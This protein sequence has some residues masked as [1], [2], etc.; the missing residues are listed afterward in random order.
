MYTKQEF[1]KTIRDKYPIYDDMDDD[2]LFDAVIKKYPE[3]STQIKKEDTSFLKETWKWIADLAKAWGGWVMQA[4]KDIINIA[5]DTS[6]P[7]EWGFIQ[8]TANTIEKK[9]EQ[10]REALD[11]TGW[12]KWVY[13]AGGAVVWAGVDVFGDMIMSWIKTIAPD[14]MEK[15]VKEVVQDKMNNTN[16]GQKIISLMN[17]Y[18]SNMEFLKKNDPEA[19][20]TYSA[21]FSYLSWLAEL[22][23]V[24]KVNWVYRSGGEI[25]KL[26]TDKIKELNQEIV[27][28]WTESLYEVKEKISSAGK[29]TTDKI[30]EAFGKIPKPK[31]EYQ[32]ATTFDGTDF[33]LE[34]TPGLY[35]D[36]IDGVF[37]KKNEEMAVQSVFPKQTKEKWINARLNSGKIALESIQQLYDDKAKWIINADIHEM[38]G[39]VQGIDEAMEYWGKKIGEYTDVDTSID[40]SKELVE[41]KKVLNTDEAGFAKDMFNILNG[42]IDRFESIGGATSIKS[43]QKIM[44]SIKWD[45]YSN[46]EITKK[47]ASTTEGKAISQFLDTLQDKF[48]ATIDIATG[49]SKELKEAKTAYSKYKKIQKDLVDSYLVAQRNSGKGLSGTAWKLWGAYEI[50]QNP[51]VSGVVKWIAMKKAGEMIGNAK[52]RDGNW[53]MLIRNLDRE[54]V[55]N[56]KIKSE[57]VKQS[58]WGAKNT[59]N[60]SSD[61][62]SSM[63][64]GNNSSAMDSSKPR[65][66]AT[67]QEVIEMVQEIAKEVENNIWDRE[68][69]REIKE[70]VEDFNIPQRYKD[71]LDEK[72]DSYIRDVDNY[73][74]DVNS[75]DF[76]D[77]EDSLASQYGDSLAKSFNQLEWIR[78]RT[79][80]T[81]GGDKMSMVEFQKT[82]AYKKF[83]DQAQEYINNKYSDGQAEMTVQELFEKMS[84]SWVRYQTKTKMYTENN[85]EKWVSVYGSIDGDVAKLSSIEI[86]KSLQNN[87]KGKKYV[88]DFENWAKENWA[89]E[90]E[91]DAYKW[92]LDFWKKMWYTVD[93]NP[94]VI[95]WVKQDYYTWFKKLESD[96]FE[97]PT[98]EMSDIMEKYSIDGNMEFRDIEAMKKEFEDAGY[99]FEYGL[100]GV[101][102]NAKKINTKYTDMENY[103]SFPD[104]VREIFYRNGD[105]QVASKTELEEIWYEVEL[106]MDWSIVSFEKKMDD[107]TR[108]QTKTSDEIAEK[109]ALINEIKSEWEAWDK[110]DIML[111]ENDIDRLES[112]IKALN[113]NELQELKDSV[114]DYKSAEEFRDAFTANSIMDLSDRKK[115]KFWRLLED[116]VDEDTNMYMDAMYTAD[117]YGSR[118][119]NEYKYQKEANVPDVESPEEMV[120]IYRWTHSSQNEMEA[121]DFVSFNKEY[122]ESHNID[123]HL[124]EKKVPAKDVVWQ[125]ADLHEWIY[126]PEKLRGWKEYTG[127]LEKLYNDTIWN[128]KFQSKW[129]SNS[130][131]ITQK[132]AKKIVRKYFKPSEVGVDFMEKITTPKWLEAFGKYKDWLI[133]FSKNPLDSTPEHEVLHAYFDM[134]LDADAKTK[135]LEDV[136]TTQKLQKNIDA[137]EWL[138]DNFV[139]FVRGREVSG[140]TDSLKKVFWDMWNSLKT[141][142]VEWDSVENLFRELEDLGISKNGISTTKTIAIWGAS[143]LE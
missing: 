130:K 133:T 106:D 26:P 16:T 9:W 108:F 28:K 102:Y 17:D 77:W 7:G 98:Q 126:S 21:S 132:E 62:S 45:L 128:E 89:T 69:L 35:D 29:I 25:V 79:K 15:K 131:A 87:W 123:G 49:S 114:K 81:K 12:A 3:Y 18:E 134:Y 92:S 93:E 70:A 13:Q 141:I 110:D 67:N 42:Y 88:S 124:I 94:Q 136:K 55:K 127:G 64:G 105:N 83:S 40:Y 23:G 30:Q 59:G 97:N 121:W 82:P 60:N 116:W 76:L 22:T 44:S 125:G 61:N 24:S 56:Y 39:G 84:D 47:M 129:Y 38:W 50:L 66:E 73:E 68:A 14:N 96:L 20:R 10:G 33:E 117:R 142:F 91:I 143:E 37:R 5:Q 109:Q 139:E 112:E 8:R 71:I 53:E 54:A 104:E 58:N 27:K 19:Y 111:D 78:K 115:H 101:P 63:T 119:N 138:A 90:V 11:E 52:S 48:D 1:I 32:K 113:T 107:W 80:T 100:D 65:V 140:I 75:M 103:D 99:T 72:I 85:P 6:I 43:M 137:E 120:T 57:N 2:S 118:W 122:A 34:A 36:I 95:D 4:S 51:S 135:V 41:L 74:K 86:K 31:K 46:F